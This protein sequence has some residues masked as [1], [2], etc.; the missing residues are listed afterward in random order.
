MATTL[1]I[2]RR[3]F[4]DRFFFSREQRSAGRHIMGPVFINTEF[5]RHPKY[6]P[7]IYWSIMVGNPKVHYRWA[8][9]FIFY[10]RR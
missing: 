4:K 10:F 5:H 8:F 6:T 9:H 1:T 7:V 2:K 3:R